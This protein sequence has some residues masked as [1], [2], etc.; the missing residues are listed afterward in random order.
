MALSNS[1]DDLFEVEFCALFLIYMGQN[2]TYALYRML[3]K[4]SILTI[5]ESVT[6]IVQ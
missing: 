6:G 5:E 2:K 1:L 4:L 3:A